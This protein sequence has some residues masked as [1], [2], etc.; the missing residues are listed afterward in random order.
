MILNIYYFVL[1]TICVIFYMPILCTKQISMKERKIR[2][3]LK[4]VENL[5]FDSFPQ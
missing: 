2:E 5:G 3:E 1:A 4:R